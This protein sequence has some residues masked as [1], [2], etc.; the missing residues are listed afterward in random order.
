MAKIAVFVQI[1]SA[2]SGSDSTIGLVSGNLQW[3]S[4]TGYS[5]WASGMVDNKT[6]DI[7]PMTCNVTTNGGLGG[8][9]GDTAITVIDGAFWTAYNSGTINLT[10]KIVRIWI[11]ANVAS[12]SAAT[13]VFTGKTSSVSTPD[14]IRTEIICDGINSLDLKKIPSM[15][16]TQ[17]MALNNPRI[18]S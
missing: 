17:E 15:V 11:G 10:N 7:A 9:D 1:E 16:I 12:Q 2:G 13:L 18:G 4:A 3:C 14:L 8:F 6:I 5:G